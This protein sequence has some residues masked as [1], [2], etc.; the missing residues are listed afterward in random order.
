MGATDREPEPGRNGRRRAWF[1]ARYVGVAAPLALTVSCGGISV[2]SRAWDPCDVGVNA[3]AN[4]FGLLLFHLPVLVL[5]Q[6]V[7]L[8]GG[9]ALAGRWIP[10]RAH[11]VCFV[12]VASVAVLA[13]ISWV[14]FAVAGLPLQNALCPGGEPPWWPWWLPPP[15]DV[16]PSGA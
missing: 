8:V 12:V 1:R 6:G 5:V 4:T 3:T 14:Y 10:S 16:S 7:V 13:A 2:V 11:R 15:P 9:Y